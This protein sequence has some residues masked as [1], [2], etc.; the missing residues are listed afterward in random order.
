MRIKSS[1]NDFYDIG[2]KFGQD[3]ILY[4][5]ERKVFESPTPFKPYDYIE[6]LQFRWYT[7]GF[8]GIKYKILHE[9]N[10]GRYL[11]KIEELDILIKE[12]KKH[13]KEAYWSNTHYRYLSRKNFIRKFNF[14]E[15]NWRGIITSLKKTFSYEKYQAPIY[16]IH[17]NNSIVVNDCLRPLKF[18]RIKDPYTAYQELHQ[19]LSN[20]A[21]P[22]K[23]IPHISDKIM[24]EAKG[25]D[26]YSFRKDK[27]K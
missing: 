6:E 7:I 17:P 23:P 21:K 26:K 24:A 18:Y 4:I 3:D 27:S 13:I 19:Y 12:H 8:C 22:E 10:S 16:V 5:R 9:L 25:F 2:Q 20:I 1:F 15:E 11:S 14:E